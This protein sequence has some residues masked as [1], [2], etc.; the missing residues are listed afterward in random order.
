MASTIA[1]NKLGVFCLDIFAFLASSS[2]HF[3]ASK[4]VAESIWVITEA[5]MIISSHISDGFFVSAFS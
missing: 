4:A 3:A 5:A 1:S 2:W